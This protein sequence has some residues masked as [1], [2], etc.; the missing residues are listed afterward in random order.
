MRELNASWAVLRDTAKRK[1][2]DQEL[3]ARAGAERP[4]AGA[5]HTAEVAADPA[6]DLPPLEPDLPVSATTHTVLRFAPVA[7]LALVLLVILIVSAYA[8]SDTDRPLETT[9]R[10]P[11]G[12]C[13]VL[14]PMPDD[15]DE[16]ATA[17]PELIEVDC[18][19]SGASRVVAKVSI[20]RP[21]PAGTS[22][23]PVSAEALSV[24]LGS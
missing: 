21:C 19:R 7:V 6:D 5:G 8:S 4:A 1:A 12:S 17:R 2:Y 15:P 23:Y 16:A 24:C 10:A 13:V 14:G 20:N 11:V 18:A 9:E 3:A 22:A